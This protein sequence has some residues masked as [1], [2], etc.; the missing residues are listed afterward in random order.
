MKSLLL[1]AVEPQPAFHSV[2]IFMD[3]NFVSFIILHRIYKIL[4]ADNY[5]S[6]HRHVNRNMLLLALPLRISMMNP[7]DLLHEA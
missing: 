6:R 7:H 3:S 4:Y 5:T 1:L 2:S